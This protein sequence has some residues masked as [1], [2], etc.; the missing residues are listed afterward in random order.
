MRDYTLKEVESWTELPAVGMQLHRDFK[1][2]DLQTAFNSLNA[3][4]DWIP[5]GYNYFILCRSTST[6]HLYFSIQA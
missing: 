5:Y 4:E 6:F 2:M 3:F 1:D